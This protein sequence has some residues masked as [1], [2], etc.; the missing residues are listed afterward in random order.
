MPR[1]PAALGLFLRFVWLKIDT[2]NAE[3]T[4]FEDASGYWFVPTSQEESAIAWPEAYRNNV[5]QTKIAACR[6]ALQ[7][8]LTAGATELRLHGCGSTTAIKRE[9]KAKGVRPFVYWSAAS[10]RISP[11]VRSAKK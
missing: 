4:V 9:A 7:Q 5:Y 8:A 3:F 6:A 1:S 2:M 11:F 10:T